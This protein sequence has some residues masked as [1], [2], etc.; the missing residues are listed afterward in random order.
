MGLDVG[1]KTIGVAISDELG[2]AA[3]PLQ[4][5]S[6][7]GTDADVAQVAKLVAERDATAIVVGLPLDLSGA[8]GRRARRVRIRRPLVR[9]FRHVATRSGVVGSTSRRRRGP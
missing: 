7:A 2:L 3:Y 4:V 1:T 5:L 8:V 9:R 6:R